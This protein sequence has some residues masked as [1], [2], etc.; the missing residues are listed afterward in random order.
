[1]EARRLNNQ[2]FF[3]KLLES[4]ELQALWELQVPTPSVC[5]KMPA[6]V[7]L[8][9]SFL[10]FLDDLDD[11]DRIQA[12][13]TRSSSAP[14]R[15]AFSKNLEAS[16][17][18]MELDASQEQTRQPPAPVLASKP[19]Q[20]CQSSLRKADI[21]E[22]GITTLMIHSLP[23]WLT[24]KKLVEALRKDGFEGTFDFVRIPFSLRSG[25]SAGY[26]FINF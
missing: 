12:A 15:V 1:M 5:K 14:S 25:C 16:A 8:G 7:P 26:G 23:R 11:L 4:R 20:P 13:R 17:D 19:P 3:A 24:Q 9:N 22:Q 2:A 18:V 10:N 6:S 21:L